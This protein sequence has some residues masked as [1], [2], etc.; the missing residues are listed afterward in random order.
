M[1]E[2]LDAIPLTLIGICLG[3]IIALLWFI[4]RILLMCWSTLQDIERHLRSM[5]MKS[6]FTSLFD[7]NKKKDKGI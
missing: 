2:L 5:D 4:H 6:D 1:M 7:T 3:S